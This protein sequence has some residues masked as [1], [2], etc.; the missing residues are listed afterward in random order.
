MAAISVRFRGKLTTG[1]LAF[2]ASFLAAGQLCSPALYAQGA[3]AAI[4]GTVTDATGAVI[5]GAAIT[6]TNVETNLQRAVTSSSAGLYVIPNLPP[7]R[8]RLQITMSGFQTRT[9]ENLELVIGQQLVSNTSLQVGEISQQVTVSG[10]APLVNTSTSQVSGLVGERQVK[11]LPLNGR[12]FDNLITLNPGTVNTNSVKGGASGSSSLGNQFAVAGRRPGENLFLWNGVEYPGGS[13]V[14]AGTPGGVS[15]QLLGIEAVREFNVMSNIDSAEYG[16]RAAGQINVVTASGTNSFHGS[17]FEFLR[18]SKLDARNF[19]DGGTIP[20]FKRNQFGGSGGGPIQK[21]KTF[22]FGNYEGFRQRL[23]LSSVAVVPDQLARTGQLPDAQGI[24]RPVAGYNPAVAPYF[25]LWPAPNGQELFLSGRPT[26]T[27]LSFTNPSNP[28]REDFGIV[29]LDHTFSERDTV[30][31]AYTV[32]DGESVAPGANPFSLLVSTLRTQLLTATE[33][34]MFSPSVV[35]T[36]TAGYARPK[37]IFILPTSVQPA[38]TM[39]F[40]PGNPLGQIK[41]GGGAGV[42][43]ASITPAGSGPN[44]GSFQIETLNNFTYEDQLHITKGIHSITTGL[45]LERLQWNAFDNAF[46]QAV[47]PDLASFLQGKPTT[48][49]FQLKGAVNPWRSWMTAWYVQDAMKL[50]SNV[51]LSV[52]VRHEFTNGYN[53]KYGLAANFVPDSNGVIITQPKIGKTLFSKN[54]ARW[55]FGPRAGLAWDPWGN[56][57]TSI[58]AGVGIAYSLLDSV[59]W[60]CRTTNPAYGTFQASNPPFPLQVNPDA[61]FPPGLNIAQGGGA[62][63]IQA[64]A[65]TPSVVNYRF[66]IEQEAG[67]GMSFRVAYVGSHGYHE[68]LRADSNLAI[69]AT[70]SAAQGNCPAGLPDGTKYFPTPTRRRNPALS[71]LVQLYTSSYN[72]YHGFQADWTRRF[73]SGLAFRANY[74]FAKSLDNAS[75]VTNLQAVGSPSVILDTYDRNRDYGLSAFD[76]RH[77]FTFSGTYE[78]PLGSGRA[79]LGGAKGVADKLVGGWQANL[80]TS[81]QSGFPVSPQLGFNQSRDGDTSNPDRPN[82]APGRTL[83]GIYLRTPQ[84]WFDPTAFALP[85]AGTYGNAGR[86]ILIGPGLQEVD[87]S[88]FKTTRLTEKWNLQFRVEFFNLLNRANFGLPAAV[89]LTT[90]G[91]PASS[92][93]RITSTATT[94]RQ[95]QFGLKINW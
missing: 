58:R 89:V 63:G 82:L 61:P 21:D 45:W 14:E 52:G 83:S 59:E 50:R 84:Q 6:A 81:F 24:Y 79:L 33:T 86:N 92:A 1:L 80:I 41:I 23:G 10:E 16:H 7:G 68:V 32:D 76:M 85:L 75:S 13:G 49:A 66:E 54:N 3:G 9:L 34:H 22:I 74:T 51:T 4:Q 36:F 25:D 5:P 27:A 20:P 28:I 57:K 55:L 64:D 29:R 90:S 44:T 62:G 46:G 87:L 30:S 39:P 15:G 31:S 70:C 26:G 71:S 47:F 48:I 88:F 60:C 19:F 17:L 67:P 95:I 65:Q 93:G 2:L 43:A 91:A 12:S 42:G 40:V 56:G 73:R 77:R 69:P 53:H 35:N 8:Y 72:N 11:D 78:L 38:G 18:N 37:L 94:S